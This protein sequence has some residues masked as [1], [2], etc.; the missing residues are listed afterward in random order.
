MPRYWFRTRHHHTCKA[1]THK[2]LVSPLPNTSVKAFVNNTSTP[3]GTSFS[4]AGGSWSQPFST[5]PAAS[6]RLF[7][8]THVVPY[9]HFRLGVDGDFQRP[10]VAG[11][12]LPHRR[13]IGEDGIGLLGLLQRFALHTS[14]ETVAHAVEDVAHGPFTGQGVIQV[15]FG[16]FQGVEDFSRGQVAVATGGPLLGVGIGLRLDDGS[17]VLGQL[18]VL[19]FTALGSPAVEVLHTAD[20]GVEFL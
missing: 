19:V 1:S 2:S 10:R 3:N 8:P 15:T 12:L 6:V 5:F 18:G 9:R 11:H 20:S 4:F 16:G 7:P 14:F 13:N 17:D